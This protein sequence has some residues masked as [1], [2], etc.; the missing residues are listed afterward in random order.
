MVHD[1][2]TTIPPDRVLAEA[3]RFFAEDVPAQA[4][5][6]EREGPG[7]L[8]LRGAGGEEI[9]LAAWSTG[10]GGGTRVRASTLFFDQAVMKFLS[11]LVALEAA[12]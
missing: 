3:R 2:T 9:A 11:R 7:F 10:E 6:P 8:T 5:F 4:A 12:A 1:S